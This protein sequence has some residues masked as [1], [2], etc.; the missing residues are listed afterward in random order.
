MLIYEWNLTFIQD[1]ERL[2]V[3]CIDSLDILV[4]SVIKLMKIEIFSSK[5]S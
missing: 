1:A 2:V 5:I 4:V 3:I